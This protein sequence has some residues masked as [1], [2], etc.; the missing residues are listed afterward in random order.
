MEARD[1]RER[2]P[3]YLAASK[4]HSDI[5]QCLFVAGA[6]VN[7]EDIQGFTPLCEAVWQRY[8]AV[9]KA[10]LMADARITPCHKLLHYAIVERQVSMQ[11]MYSVRL[12]FTF[13]SSVG[14]S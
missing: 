12:L 3:L 7:C 2:T 14:L 5:V 13:T 8:P 4:G 11:I 6:N 10:L 9:V 1:N